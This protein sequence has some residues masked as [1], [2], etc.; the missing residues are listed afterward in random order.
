[1][2]VF[3]DYPLSVLFMIG[4]LFIGIGISFIAATSWPAM[5]FFG[6][7]LCMVAAGSAL[8]KKIIVEGV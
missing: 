4:V 6:I 2:N 1:M 3:K 8:M 5:I 7:G